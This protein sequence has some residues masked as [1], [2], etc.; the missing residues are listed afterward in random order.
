MVG[1]TT[2]AVLGILAPEAITLIGRIGVKAFAAG[3]VAQAAS[4][5]GTAFPAFNESSAFSA[6]GESL[7]DCL[8]AWGSSQDFLGM[9]SD[10]AA[11]P[12]AVVEDGVVES[13]RNSALALTEA[14]LEQAEEIVRTFIL[15][16]RGAVLSVTPGLEVKD[17]RDE[18]R[19]AETTAGIAD[20]RGMLHSALAGLSSEEPDESNTDAGKAIESEI[21]RSRA[22]MDR[23]RYATAADILRD[24]E[25]RAVAMSARQLSRVK[26]NLGVCE[27]I[28][29]E[30]GAREHFAEAAALDPAAKAPRL[31]L[32]MAC[33]SDGDPAGALAA[34]DAIIATA[35]G[36]RALVRGKA[37][38]F[39]G[40][41]DRGSLENL[42]K[43][44]PWLEDEREG[45]GSLA[46]AYLDL[47]QQE[48][49]A[50]LAGRALAIDRTDAEAHLLLGLARMNQVAPSLSTRPM[51]LGIPSEQV[52]VLEDASVHLS[53]ALSLLSAWGAAPQARVAAANL[54]TCLS[55]LGEHDMAIATARGALP[56]SGLDEDIEEILGLAL[57]RAG[58]TDDAVHH[59]QR[60]SPDLS[61][62]ATDTLSVILVNGG[63]YDG[64]VTLLKPLVMSDVGLASPR[65]I[66]MLVKA[67]SALK[68][69][70]TLDRVI[71]AVGPRRVEEP[72]FVILL[73]EIDL[74]EGRT[75][76]ARDRVASRH[77]LGCDDLAHEETL[78]LADVWASLGDYAEATSLLRAVAGKAPSQAYTTYV[79]YAFRANQYGEALD[80]AK[81]L[82]ESGVTDPTVVRIESHI[83]ESIGDL[84]N[85]VRALHAIVDTRESPD[86]RDV[87]NMARLYLRTGRESDARLALETI[88]PG[89]LGDRPRDLMYFAQLSSFF[90]DGRSVGLAA[91][92]VLASPDDPDLW[93]G[94]V[95]IFLGRQDDAGG[96]YHAETV[97]PGVSV[98]LAFGSDVEQYS[99]VLDADFKGYAGQLRLS[100]PLA[101][102]ILGARVGDEIVVNAAG[103]QDIT[104]RVETIVHSD[105]R[106]FQETIAG[107]ARRF[108]GRNEILQMSISEN[109]LGQVK[110]ILDDRRAF[111]SQ[112][113]KEFEKARFPLS[114]LSRLL[115]LTQVELW[116][117]LV[118]WK[119]HKLPGFMSDV[120]AFG[121]G[122][123]L[124]LDISSLL[125]LDLLG[126]LELA[127]LLNL[128]LLV[129]QDA[130]DELQGLKTKLERMPP[131]ATLASNDE[132]LSVSEID[133]ASTGMVMD[134]LGRILD[135]IGYRCRVEPVEARL[136]R[137]E[138][139]TA[140]ADALGPVAESEVLV[141]SARK[142]PVCTEDA[143][144][145]AV[146][147]ADFGVTVVRALDIAAALHSRGHLSIDQ[148]I[149]GYVK[150]Y[151]NNYDGL[152]PG[153]AQVLE[154][155]RANGW[156]LDAAARSLLSG[157]V[158]DSS[159]SDADSMVM[160]AEI[161]AAAA[162]EVSI[163]AIRDAIWSCVLEALLGRLGTARFTDPL[164]AKVA[165]RISRLLSH[166]TDDFVAFVTAWRR[167]RNV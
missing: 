94:Y 145:A 125:T 156:M 152:R 155:L 116:T 42:R 80:A 75:D 154:A 1:P 31:N 105:V 48:E 41:G 128:E 109:D 163:S 65:H 25:A 123:A 99:I 98:E 103:R 117:G 162:S 47:G 165:K 6:E 53:E 40:L 59:L 5:T 121:H 73:A 149:T 164:V 127:P 87:L 146:L 61:K 150:L 91:S 70:E 144:F 82:R 10:I 112:A 122:T 23:R 83:Y 26:N 4:R 76:E 136:D 157:A 30:E 88:D 141:G 147:R 143:A 28:F 148:V 54:A 153:A 89:G 13:F 81:A 104:C 8:L 38:M 33:A 111:V 32:A 79:V 56:L 39:G 51:S 120:E 138:G 72:T 101:Q 29:G 126:V 159:Y 7:D 35:P 74:A 49:A 43:E 67:A 84:P 93:L 71:D 16:L 106:L 44:F 119:G 131:S 113:L 139:D 22:F 69:Q 140:L 118:G 66:E 132:G 50:I 114:T 17:L 20:M 160:A 24:L 60:V 15:E 18:A 21:D 130:V 52:A 90:G 77:G 158:R 14:V 124:I 86:A 133:P 63:D 36:D 167:A 161:V 68:D 19:H 58:R 85:A 34:I 96:A 95:G 129:T 64:V 78:R 37:Q 102:V 151:Q 97:Q 2:L 27:L 115:G 100:D 107:F 92:A 3:P 62:A 110:S 57:N 137:G 134:M 108:P 135:F 46:S 45:L 142:A 9:M 55:L 12:S 166:R 11:A